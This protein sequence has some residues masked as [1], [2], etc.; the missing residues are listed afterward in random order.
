MANVEALLALMHSHLDIENRPHFVRDVAFGE[1]AYR[2]HSGHVLHV[3]TAALRNT[4]S[5]LLRGA[6]HTRIVS[7]PQRFAV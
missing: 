6:G 5:N 4:A 2:V 7:A 1:G 3:F